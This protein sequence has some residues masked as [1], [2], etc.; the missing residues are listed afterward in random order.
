MTNIQ[1]DSA[2]SSARYDEIERLLNRYPDVDD[3]ELGKLKHWFVR[4]ASA[5]DVASLASRHPRGYE[6]FRSDIDGFK[7]KD[8]A[9]LAAIVGIVGALLLLAL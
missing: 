7:P 6:Q 1:A 4:E 3:T 8:Y 5:F 2:N 9:L